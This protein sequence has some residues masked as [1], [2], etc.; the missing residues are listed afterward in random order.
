MFA[1]LWE[2][3]RAN[4]EAEWVRTFAMITGAP[5]KVSGQVHDRQPV[6]LPPTD[7]SDWLSG[8]P[9]VAKDI[10][11]NHPE[12]LLVFHPVSKAVSNVRNQGEALIEPIEG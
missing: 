4:E 5:G 7:W 9:D 2:A 11:A 6:I 10:L 3:W 1:G 8:E 12:P